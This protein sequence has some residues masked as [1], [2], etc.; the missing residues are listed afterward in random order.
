MS[1]KSFVPNNKVWAEK[2]I[3]VDLIAVFLSAD[4]A[5]MAKKTVPEFVPPMASRIISRELDD[6]H[7]ET[8]TKN[9]PC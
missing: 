6:R 9:E 5:S 8:H 3:R 2:W 7:P 4:S 1:L